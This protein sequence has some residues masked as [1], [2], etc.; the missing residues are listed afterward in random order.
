MDRIKKV[1]II[2][3][4]SGI[5]KCSLTVS[6]PIFSCIGVEPCPFPTAILSNHTGFKEFF[7]SDFTNEMESYKKAWDNMG[8]K[9][10]GIYSGFLGSEQQI[11]IISQFIKEHNESLIVVDPVMGDEGITYST[12]TKEMCDS[13]KE[14]VKL[15]HVVTPNL[16]EACILTNRDYKTLKVDKDM[17]L[18][19]GKEISNMGPKEVIITGVIQGDEIMNFSYNKESD[20][21]YYY[22]SKYKKKYFSGTG[23]IFS[24]IICAM[25]LKGKTSREAIKIASDFI[26]NAIEYTSN[27]DIDGNEGVMFEPFLKE[28][29]L[30]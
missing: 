16:T 14:L 27:F 13:M 17:L 15:A 24:S 10:E 30:N 12:Y 6:I 1:A 7:F 19:I 11:N 25:L 9:F 8:V 2:N 21:S 26:Y 5:G 20:D 29:I 3:D 18:T 22:I 28:L 4:M 23:D